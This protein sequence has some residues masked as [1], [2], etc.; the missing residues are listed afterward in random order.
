MVGMGVSN[1]LLFAGGDQS[2]LTKL[3][4]GLEHSIAAFAVRLAETLN[5]AVID[6][7]GHPRERVARDGSQERL[8]AV[9]GEAADEDRQPAKC[10]LIVRREEVVAPGD[11]LPHRVLPIRGIPMAAR[12]QR[13]TFAE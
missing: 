12:Q 9:E 7:R 2:L 11:C 5:Q 1:V 6:E 13:E 8:S 4:N 3:A 10:R